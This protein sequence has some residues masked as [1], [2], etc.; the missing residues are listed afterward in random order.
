MQIGIN[1]QTNVYLILSL[2]SSFASI[3]LF[4]TE[5]GTMHSGTA[6]SVTEISNASF[7]FGQKKIS[8]K[9]A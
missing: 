7:E 3:D 8:Y 2:F 4:F 5:L 9:A 1:K 6:F